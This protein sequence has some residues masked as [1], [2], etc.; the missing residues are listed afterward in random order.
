MFGIVLEVISNVIQE[1]TVVLLLT[2]HTVS[3]AVYMTGQ[4]LASP[5][6][7]S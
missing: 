3:I 4:A 2:S 1:H 7:V 6:L 5:T